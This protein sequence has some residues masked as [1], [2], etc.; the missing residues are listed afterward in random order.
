MYLFQLFILAFVALRR[1]I[2]R[3]L[4]TM[5]GIVI[6]VS[7]V[8]TM[9]EIGNG[10][11]ASIAKSIAGMGSNIL[12]ISPASTSKSGVSSGSG[13]SIT[14][15]NDDCELIK[16]ECPSIRGATPMIT[17]RGLQIAMGN[18]NWTPSSVNA[19]S[20]DYF[21]VRGYG[22]ITEGRYFDA[23]EVRT[24][25][26]VC[27]LGETVAVNLFGDASLAVDAKVRLNNLPFRVVGVLPKKGANMMGMDQDDIVV[28][29][30]TTMRNRLARSG[31]SSLGGGGGSAVSSTNDFYP[32][33]GASLYPEPDAVQSRNTPLP[34]RFNNVDAIIVNAVSSDA[35]PSAIQEVTEVL[36][37][38]HRLRTQD[39]DDFVIR[40]MSEMLDTMTATSGMMTKLLLIV[41]MISLL[42][43]GVG[44]MNIML[45][46]VT[47]RTREIG[48]RMAIGARGSRILAQFL[49]ES[50]VLC[51]LG[52]IIGILLGRGA[53]IVV[54]NV[55]GWPI[56]ISVQAIVLSAG[57]SALIG[58]VFGF[59]PAWRASR[60]NP[61]EALRHE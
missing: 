33:V 59:Y 10:A 3:S 32:K 56:E 19:G 18:Q 4:L 49:V 40:D 27:T 25:A 41:A 17:R 47:E 44:I 22:E 55:L 11:A 9:M 61:I 43:G 15:T 34:V 30:W 14:L 39:E 37:R 51:V 6:G 16:I 42:V 52:G 48:L 7:A 35:I 50:I 5:L 54:A 13:G 31:T 28:V 21:T 57:V 1:N 12:I 8:I 38:S 24:S 23:H 29:P 45:V 58:M 20:E 36:R 53:S 2:L 60:L 46:S 26:L